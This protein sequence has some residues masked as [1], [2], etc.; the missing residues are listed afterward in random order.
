MTLDAFEEQIQ[1]APNYKQGNAT[2]WIKALTGLNK[3]LDRRPLL[4]Y[5]AFTEGRELPDVT[6]QV[7]IRWYVEHDAAALAR[8][9]PFIPVDQRENLR[10]AINKMAEHSLEVGRGLLSYVT[11]KNVKDGVCVTVYLSGEAYSAFLNPLSLY[12]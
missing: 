1:E 11:L 9:L 10:A 8:T 3:S 2:H 6:I 5:F 7:P 12:I 4:A